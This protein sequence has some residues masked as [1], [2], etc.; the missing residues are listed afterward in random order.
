MNSALRSGTEEWRRFGFTNGRFSGSVISSDL[1]VAA[2][3]EDVGCYSETI[4]Q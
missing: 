1:E 3:F 2:E 4:L